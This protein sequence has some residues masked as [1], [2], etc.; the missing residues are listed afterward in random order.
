M[1][2]MIN[3]QWR[4]AAHRAGIVK[5][6]DLVLEEAPIPTPGDGEYLVRMHYLMVHPAARLGL[7]RAA[8][9]DLLAGYGA[10]EVVRSR[11]PDVREGEFV[12]GWTGW[13]DY[14]LA[15]G[16]GQPQLERVPPEFPLPKAISVLGPNGMTAY[17]G[18]LD[19]GQPKPGET[20]VVS[21]AA[22]AVGSLVGQIARLRGCR[23]VGIAGTDAKC[24]WLTGA[25]GFD[26]AINYHTEDV[27]TR[28]QDLCPAG[29]DVYFDN[30]GGEL[31][32]LAL[33]QIAFRGRVVLCGAVSTYNSDSPV[34]GP[35]NLLPL[36]N[37]HA[38]IEGFHCSHYAARFPEAE[39]ELLAWLES[40]ELRAI[41]TILQGMERV[42]A[43][44]IQ[45]FAGGNT[46]QMLVQLTAVP[47]SP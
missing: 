6:S 20:V 4:V 37:Q 40:G 32:D 18:L 44:L 45:L 11:H 12:R 43:A 24:S 27:A 26:S 7:G 23:V 38:R 36:I 5:E 33:T 47:P 14:T 1:T 29:I 13:Q 41:E 8:I 3:R 35:R 31:L 34:S 39:R 42:P 46:G 22:G 10:G 16:N 30:V 17:F 15:G 25:L 2:G 9:G 19:V 28:V 21:G